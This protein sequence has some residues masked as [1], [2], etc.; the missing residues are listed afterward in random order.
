M[1]SVRGIYENGGIKLLE[2]IS[3]QGRFEVI[4]TFLE[5]GPKASI[6]KE[7]LAGLLS[8]L[9]ENDFNEFLECYHRSNQD[10]FSGRITIL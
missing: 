9:S 8:D 5:D 7:N 2:Q 6:Q 4:I 1:L 3:K 10:W